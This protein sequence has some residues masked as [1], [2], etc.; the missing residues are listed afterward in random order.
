MAFCLESW[1]DDS[2]VAHLLET[3]AI[4]EMPLQIKTDD[5]QT[6]VSTEIHQFYEHYG[7]KPILDIAYRSSHNK[8]T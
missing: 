7:M 4:L 1:R 5:A 2:E 8:K 3:M 6:Y